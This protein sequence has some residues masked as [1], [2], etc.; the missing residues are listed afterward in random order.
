MPTRRYLARGAAINGIFYVVGGHDN[1]LDV[2]TLEAF[3]PS[4]GRWRRLRPMPTPRNTS[5]VGAVDGKLYVAGGWSRSGHVAT[6]EVYD[7]ARDR[8]ESRSRMPMARNAMGAVVGGLFYAVGGTASGNCT[9]ALHAYDPRTDTWS[10]KA[11]LST[12]R[13][14]LSVAVHGGKIYAAGGNDTSGLHPY[15]S[16][17]VYDPSAD[18]WSGLPDMPAP[19]SG[20]S[21][22]SVDGRLF[23]VG[24]FVSPRKTPPSSGV[25][26]YD[27]AARIWAMHSPMLVGRDC[28]ASGVIRGTLYVAGGTPDGRTMTSLLETYDPRRDKVSREVRTTMLAPVSGIPQG[29]DRRFSYQTPR[30]D[31]DNVV[32]RRRKRDKDFALVMGVEH[33]R[34]A[35][36]RADFA[37]SDA[38][39]FGRYAT[40][41]LGVPQENV[42]LL[43]GA[44]ATRAD[45]ERYLEEWLPRNADKDS[46]VYFYFAGHGAPDPAKGTAYLLPWDGDPSF[47]K[48]SAYPLSKLYERL[49]A[50]PSKE[51]VVM[52]DACF[53]GVGGRSVIAQGLRP[54][55]MV[56]DAPKLL[57]SKLSILTAAARDQVAG[58]LMDQ[59][60]G[61][62]TYY[63][64]KGMNGAADEDGDGSLA[65]SDLFRYVHANVQRSAHRQNREQTPQLFSRTGHL[66]LY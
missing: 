4:S 52:L 41:V 1:D 50:L 18:S 19:L 54:L 45:L 22:E 33:Y 60:H 39:Y 48:T 5:A 23:L 2:G 14:T 17:E 27:P 49:E 66:E 6:L 30:S 65:L 42:I 10:E 3:D 12:A 62:F 28:M 44:K 43:T 26:S 51:V 57:G 21:L 56:A 32:D 63:L 46:R 59:G 36:P 24:G 37:E 61:M 47:L 13:C 55:V 40:K 11:S 7:P 53:S 8:W 31:V 25:A 15:S 20:A 16:M 64:L 38:G 35:I 9:N 34:S 58:S 29:Q